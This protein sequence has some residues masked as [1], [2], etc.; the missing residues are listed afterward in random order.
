MLQPLLNQVKFSARSV[1]NIINSTVWELEPYTKGEQSAN[2]FSLGYQ[3]PS[4]ANWSYEL[5]IANRDGKTYLLVKQFGGVVGVLEL[6]TGS[7]WDDY[8]QK[9]D[10]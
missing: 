5:G 4:A 8:N 7:E 10:K 3:T 1:R 2:M 6:Y 9:E